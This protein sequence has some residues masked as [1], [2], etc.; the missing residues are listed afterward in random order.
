MVVFGDLD[1]SCGV[2]MGGLPAIRRSVFGRGWHHLHVYKQVCL[3][4]GAFQKCGLD[5]TLVQFAIAIQND[6]LGWPNPLFSMQVHVYGVA[7]NFLFLFARQLSSFQVKDVIFILDLVFGYPV[8]LGGESN[9][10]HFCLVPLAEKSSHV[11]I[12]ALRTLVSASLLR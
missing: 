9:H 1:L 5:W 4:T 11:I 12:V 6:A 7:V 2:G 8:L 3:E 10:L